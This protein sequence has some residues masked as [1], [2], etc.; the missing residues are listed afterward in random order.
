M[1]F[2][3]ILPFKLFDILE[4]SKSILNAY[5]IL[6]IQSALRTAP[7]LLNDAKF[8]FAAGSPRQ[9]SD[10]IC[11]VASTKWLLEVVVAHFNYLIL[12]INKIGWSNTKIEVFTICLNSEKMLSESLKNLNFWTF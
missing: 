8:F 9:R 2:N 12:F 11:V 10:Q 3:R 1:C 6:D 7:G 4:P 5:R